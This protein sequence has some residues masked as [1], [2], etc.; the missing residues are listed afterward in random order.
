MWLTGIGRPVDRWLCQQWVVPG[1][2]LAVTSDRKQPEAAVHV[3]VAH[4]VSGREQP[5]HSRSSWRAVALPGLQ[6]QGA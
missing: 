3:S 5:R 2:E 4:L 6:I 1:M